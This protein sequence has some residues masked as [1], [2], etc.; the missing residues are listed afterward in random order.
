MIEGGYEP[1]G[2]DYFVEGD[3]VV[4]IEGPLKGTKGVVIQ[5]KG[6]D[7]FVL[8]IDAIQHAVSCQIDRKLLKP[9][10]VKNVNTI[11]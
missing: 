10:K 8:K 9:L 2:I 1:E 3:H 6:K 5:I 4:I 11:L 7:Q